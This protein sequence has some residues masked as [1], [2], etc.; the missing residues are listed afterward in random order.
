MRVTR[1]LCVVAW[2]GSA[3]AHAQEASPPAEGPQTGAETPDVP[4]TPDAD[5]PAA[6]PEASSATP[7][8]GV[9]T[10]A[11]TSAAPSPGATP[12]EAATPP[13]TEPDEP[14][15]RRRSGAQV[16]IT[17][18]TPQTGTLFG[19]APPPEPTASE[20]PGDGEWKFD[21]HGFLRA[22]LRLGIGEV[23][24]AP[25]EELNGTK[26]HAP[27]HIP[28][29]AFTDWRYTNNMPGPWVELRFSYGNTRVTG[30]VLIGP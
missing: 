26:L 15:T 22:P 23:D 3:E 11:A 9:T 25:E 6:S 12:D 4:A 14:A 27:P 16:G 29:G 17:P 13:G 24:N 2:L 7:S 20:A 8:Q 30:N 28:D 18:G 5:A 19:A 10:E 21:F 1:L